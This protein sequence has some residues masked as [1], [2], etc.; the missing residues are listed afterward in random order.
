M[1]VM[2]HA[3]VPIRH[4]TQAPSAVHQNSQQLGLVLAQLT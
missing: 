4:N 3:R 2:C 1:K